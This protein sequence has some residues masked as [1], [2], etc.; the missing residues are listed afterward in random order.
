MTPPARLCLQILQI[1]IRNVWTVLFFL[2]SLSILS[3]A[4][5]FWDDIVTGF[6]FAQTLVVSGLDYL[7]TL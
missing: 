7:R 2:S 6:Q 4:N 5:H 3:L 1:I